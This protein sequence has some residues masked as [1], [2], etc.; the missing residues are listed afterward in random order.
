MFRHLP[1]LFTCLNLLCGCLAI[2][3]VFKG[4]IALFSACIAG[5]LFFDFLDGLAA[6]ALNAGSLLGKELDSLADMVSFG[7]VP[8]AIMY[9][10]FLISVP[11][12]LNAD[13]QWVR[14][15]SFLPFIITVFS[16]LRLAKFNIDTRQTDSFLGLPTPAATIF[17][18]GIALVIEYDRFHLTPTLLNSYL[19]GGLALV[20]S[21]MLVSEVPLFA[22]KFKSFGWRNNRMQYILLG[23]GAVLTWFLH[24]AAIPLTVILYVILSFINHNFLQGRT[25]APS[26]PS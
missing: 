11:V 3:F 24:A 19:I 21:Y 14:M 25:I 7:L 23:T 9:H 16:A 12:S 10:L 20:I 13:A 17:V 5:S 18:T 1:N 15:V 2:V 22:L 26:Q 8:G 6:R 4:E